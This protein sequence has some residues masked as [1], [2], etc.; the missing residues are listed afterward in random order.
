MKDDM[1]DIV[2]SFHDLANMGVRHFGRYFK[3]PKH[4]NMGDILKI[5][6][7][8][9]TIVKAAGNEALFQEVNLEQLMKILSSFQEER[10]PGPNG[11]PVEFFQPFFDLVGEDLLKMIEELKIQGKLSR[12]LN[13]TFLALIP[14]KDHTASFN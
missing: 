6:S 11:W 3:V 2:K 12:G 4:E 9:P 1:G 13:S 5:I 10:S 8:F 7:T 14:K